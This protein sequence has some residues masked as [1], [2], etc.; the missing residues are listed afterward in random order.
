MTTEKGHP[1]R[2]ELLAMAYVDGELTDEAR[3][4]LEARLPAE[5]E[6]GRQIAAYQKLELLG[7]AQ[8]PPEPMDHEWR[9]LE[10][11][12]VQRAGLGLGWSLV[13]ACGLGLLGWAAWAVASDPE[14]ELV[15]KLLIGGAMLGAA[16]LFLATLRARLR[17]LSY[18]P[19]T[20]VER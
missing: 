5:P 19:Y 18:D 14:L 20:E 4:E 1:T 12:G 8:A 3:A 7:R 6:L 11:D 13:L 10:R 9:R 15:P 17:T 16:S 2:D